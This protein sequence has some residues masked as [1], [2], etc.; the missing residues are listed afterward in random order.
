MLSTTTESGS[1]PS[2][3]HYTANDI[4]TIGGGEPFGSQANQSWGS[5][6]SGV[7]VDSSGDVYAV[8]VNNNNVV[9]TAATTHTQWGQ[10]MTAGDTY[11][12]AGSAS[13]TQGSSGDGGPATSALLNPKGVGVDA[14]GDLYIADAGNSRIQEIPATSGTQWGQS[15]TA[16]DIYTIAGSSWEFR[17]LRDRRGSD[18]R[19]LHLDPI[20]RLR[21]GRGPL[22]GELGCQRHR[23]G[24]R[25]LSYSVGSVDD[26]R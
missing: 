18:L 4:Y 22:S 16:G 17:K 1:Q 5:N 7:A 19:P 2:M 14:A 3:D 6:T 15:M 23:R 20:N 12:V 25:H 24:R 11:L 8:N 10:S 9:E 26:R 13:G 21:L